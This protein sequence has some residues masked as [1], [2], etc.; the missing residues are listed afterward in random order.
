M[1]HVVRGLVCPN[2]SIIGIS[3][4]NGLGGHMEQLWVLPHEP[5]LQFQP[6][7]PK[8]K[9]PVFAGLCPSIWCPFCTSAHPLSLSTG[10]SATKMQ[11]SSLRVGLTRV[12]NTLCHPPILS[13]AER[14]H[15]IKSWQ[16]C[17]PRHDINS[18]TP[19]SPTPQLLT[20]A[21]ARVQEM[22]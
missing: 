13:R 18:N 9:A 7:V 6:P 12:I 16:N 21:P 19:P 2:G 17:H 8:T 3:F 10:K 14:V 5:H 15:K 20:L 1:A 22:N 11:G 4:P